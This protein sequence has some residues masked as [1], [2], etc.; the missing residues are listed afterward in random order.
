MSFRVPEVS[1]YSVYSLLSVFS[2]TMTISGPLSAWK[3]LSFYSLV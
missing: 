2:L 3:I 1:S